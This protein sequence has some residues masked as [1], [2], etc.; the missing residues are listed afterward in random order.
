MGQES[1]LRSSGFIRMF[2]VKPDYLDIDLIQFFPRFQSRNWI[3][4][5]HTYLV[6]GLRAWLALVAIS[7]RL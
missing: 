7:F 3:F 4:L 1:H 2:V 6:L 5:F